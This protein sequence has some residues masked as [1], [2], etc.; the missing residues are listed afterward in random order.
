MNKNAEFI[1]LNKLR[2]MLSSMPAYVQDYI[3]SIHNTTQVKTRYE[4]CKDIQTFLNYLSSLFDK[5]DISLSDLQSLSKQDFEIY[6][7]YLEHYEKDGREIT[8]DRCSIKRKMT[9]LREFFAYL[10]ASGMITSDEI[11]K[12]QLPKL[13]KK[14]IVYMDSDETKDF[15]TTIETGTNLSKKEQDYHAKQSTR[16]LAICYLLLSTGIR[17]SECANLDTDDIDMTKSCIRVIRKGG[18]EDTV[19]FSDEA[20]GYIQAYIEERTHMKGL[21]DDE[22]ALFISS[23]KRRMSV[24]SIEILVKKYAKRSV[25]LKHITPHKLRS[26]FATSLYEETGDIYLV[27]ETLGHKDVTTTKEHYANLSD[28]RKEENRNKISL[29]KDN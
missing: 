26:T 25:P 3:R 24:R 14:E 23:Q 5:S 6:F 12:L 13:H 19:Y 1:Y 29:K 21:K 9:A 22:T 15:L 7:E 17:V 4:Y 27:A 28:K 2:D 11:R 16:D 20:S 10:F 8:N 18:N